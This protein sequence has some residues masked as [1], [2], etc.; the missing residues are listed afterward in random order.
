MADVYQKIRGLIGTIFQ[1][2]LGGP[3]LKPSGTGVIEHRDS[4]DA[5]F[6]I[7]RGAT[8]VGDNDLVT[9]LYADQLT[10][11]LIV[12]RQADTSSSIPANTATR[13]FVVVT[14]AGSGAVIGDVLFD[15]G[16]GVGTMTILAGGPQEGRVIVVTDA[17]AGGTIEFDAD[18]MYIWDDDAL[19]WI[20]AGDIGSVTGADRVICVPFDFNDQGGTVDSTAEVPASAIITKSIIKITT[21]FDGT[22]PTITLG[23]SASPALAQAASVNRPTQIAEYHCEEIIAWGGV[24]DEVRVTVGGTAATQGVGTA[25]LFY[26]TPNT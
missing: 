13:G 14:T 26:S 22:S 15:D 19:T 17:L 9:K 2:G 7:A 11:P 21:D 16:T 5:A 18:T 24:A 8:P 23:N 1:L 25:Y 4:A 20:K 10:K 6:A 12:K 3:Q